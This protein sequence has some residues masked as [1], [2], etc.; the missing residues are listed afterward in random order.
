[1]TQAPEPPLRFNEVKAGVLRT[2]DE[3]FDHLV[4]FPSEPHYLEVDGY[5][6]VAG[7]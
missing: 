1:M 2:P 5:G 4:D 3:C 7:A 6:V